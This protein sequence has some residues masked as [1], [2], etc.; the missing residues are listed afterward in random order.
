MDL[1]TILSAII[2][3]VF[4]SIY[5]F[6]QHRYRYWKNRG[7]P[8]LKTTFP[9]GNSQGFRIT[10]HFSETNKENYDA[11]KGKGLF[12]GIFLFFT[13]FAIATNLD[14]IKT[15]LI[16]DFNVFPN[17]GIYYNEKDDPLSAHLLN[18][19]DDRWKNLRSKLT[20]TFTSGKI[21]SMF[22]TVNNVVDNLV[23][24][25]SSKTDGD[26]INIFE[27]FGRFTTDVIASCAFGIES[28][29]LKDE[30]SKFYEMGQK[31]FEVKNVFERMIRI[32]Y[33]DIA[34]KFGVKLLN[35]EMSDFYYSITKDTVE[36]REKS[37]VERN[38]FMNLMVQMKKSNLINL[39]EIAAQSLIFY[40]AG[41]ETT[42][43]TLTYCIYE[44]SKNLELQ[45][46]ARNYTKELLKKHKNEVS[47][48]LVSDASY[49]EQIINGE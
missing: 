8:G 38:D 4:T 10:K 22:S 30:D 2:F 40:V 35:K 20:P 5:L 14:F 1:I 24:R 25:L 12:G 9:Y 41:H 34:R 44:L 37:S 16:K 15:I 31:A 49:L 27:V 43:T 39:N 19:E 11:L 17:R 21:K 26:S 46:K 29:S 23:A 18:I 6:A 13:P 36:Y 7:V 47:Y 45:E 48:E 33:P 3:V 32:G 28:N 42:A